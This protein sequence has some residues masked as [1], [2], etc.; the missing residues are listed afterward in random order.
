MK[1]SSCSVK[2]VEVPWVRP[3]GG[4][5]LLMKISLQSMA[6][7]LPVAEVSRQTSVSE[8]HIWHLVRTRIDEGWKKTD[9]SYVK[10]MGVAETSTRKGHKYGTTFLEIKGKETERSRG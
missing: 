9:W 6:K 10:R 7:V 3:N 1:A 2:T 5:T 8:D 4:F